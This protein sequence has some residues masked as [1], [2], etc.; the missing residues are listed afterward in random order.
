MRRILISLVLFFSLV[1]IGYGQYLQLG[2]RT[3]TLSGSEFL[4][5]GVWTDPYNHNWQDWWGMSL[6][7]FTDNIDF[8]M[9]LYTQL[10]VNVVRTMVDTLSIQLSDFMQKF[11]YL[12]TECASHGLLLEVN[13]LAWAIVPGMYWAGTE[14]YMSAST[15][16]GLIQN[17]INTYKNDA[18]IGWWGIRGEAVNAFYCVPGTSPCVQY[19]PA[20]VDSVLGWHKEIYDYIKSIDPNHLVTMGNSDVYSTYHCIEVSVAG[21]KL[22]Q[23][24]DFY[25][26]QF[27]KD[28]REWDGK[29]YGEDSNPNSYISDSYYGVLHFMRSSKGRDMLGRPMIIGEVGYTHGGSNDIYKAFD[30]FNA[31]GHV[32]KRTKIAG[33]CI[34][35][36]YDTGT[37]ATEMYGLFDSSGVINLTGLWYKGYSLGESDYDIWN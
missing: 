3:F 4:V 10:G 1:Q 20:S 12:V 32:V 23:M 29:M 33:I 18:T 13:V 31:M 7:D 2:N 22:S 30:Y 17:L 16:E 26:F 15:A 11:D 36:D 27:Y 25:D 24:D 28:P 19:P 9:S 14:N 35:A 37:S 34:W 5:K 6:S 21:Y 8:R